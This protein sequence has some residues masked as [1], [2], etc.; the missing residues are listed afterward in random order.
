MAAFRIA[1]MVITSMVFC[2]VLGHWP[3]CKPSIASSG[4][5]LDGY[6]CSSAG[7]KMSCP[8]VLACIERI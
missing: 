4:R 8:T 2:S 1:V 7:R 6:V 5:P 3:M